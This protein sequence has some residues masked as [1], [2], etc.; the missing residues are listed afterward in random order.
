MKTT[1]LLIV[2]SVF[3]ATMLFAQEEIGAAPPAES[4]AVT[5]T[6]P[7]APPSRPPITLF[8]TSQFDSLLN[9]IPGG[10]SIRQNSQVV[11]IGTDPSTGDFVVI[12]LDA[13]GD[14][15]KLVVPRP[16]ERPLSMTAS[17]SAVPAPKKLEQ[18]GRSWFIIETTLK[19]AFTYLSAYT[20]ILSDTGGSNSKLIAGLSLLT[21]GGTLYG[22]FA[23]T[24]NME[25][26]Y[27]KVALMNFGSTALGGYYPFL[28]SS[29]LHNATSINDPYKQIDSSGWNGE[30]NES[31]NEPTATDHIRAWS[32]MIG[33]PAG[34]YLGS[35][36][37]IVD[38]DDYGK[39]ALISYFSQTFGALAFALPVFYYDDPTDRDSRAYLSTS[40]ALSM[41]MLPAGFYGGYLLTRNKEISAGRGALPW[42]TGVGGALTGFGL[43]ML[44]DEY[45]GI[46]STRAILASTI[47]GYAGGT[48]L[49]LS[50]HPQIDYT[51][52]QS[53]F[54]GASVAAGTG[55]GV[56]F[57]LIFEANNHRAYILACIAGGWTGFY[58]GE[59]LS[60]QLFEK[61]GRD[62]KHSGL[63]LDL[64][65]LAALPLLLAP[66]SSAGSEIAL[67]ETPA[68]P[69]A[70][71]E[72][73]F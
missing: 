25:L 30:R 41:A 49:S 2:L 39:V 67:C 20:T 36:L 73:R 60:L 37:G 64:P 38:K 32:S 68:L 47:A 72:W 27:G 50:Y 44:G 40:T 33:F 7:E 65:G 4:P 59:R 24:R 18:Y 1:A 11:G 23:F 16:A 45:H 35:R 6:E 57:P 19:S 46:A 14:P 66:P 29:F 69:L 70:N 43:A 12:V 21:I 63:R 42:V 9:L 54:I 52:W 56:S 31:Y 5:A 55:I 17:T 15:R 26:G 3:L 61:S 28:L 10:D 34:M 71:L 53:V 58:F 22:S 8:A 48:W 13:N 51:F 62:A